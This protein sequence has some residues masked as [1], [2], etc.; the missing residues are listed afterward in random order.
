[1]EH[2]DAVGDGEDHLHVVLGEEQGEP[3]LAPDTLDELDGLARLLGRHA[4]RRLVEEEDLRLEGE[5]DT[6]LD[7]LLVAV[8]EKARH[9]V[10]LVE[11][12][13]RGEERFC[14]VTI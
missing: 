9:L 7:L 13:H 4:R 11:Q 12:A 2:G 3:A 10:G 1:V 6:Q 8:G 14:L 5:R